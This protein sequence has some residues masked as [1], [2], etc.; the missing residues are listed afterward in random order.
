VEKKAAELQVEFEDRKRTMAVENERTLSET[1][2]RYEIGGMPVPP[3][4]V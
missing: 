2:K 4:K 3:K 1:S